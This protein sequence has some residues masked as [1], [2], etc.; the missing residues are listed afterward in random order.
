VAWAIGFCL[1]HEP[2]A[3]VIN[4]LLSLTVELFDL[5]AEMKRDVERIEIEPD[6]V[7]RPAIVSALGRE[8]FLKDLFDDECLV[9]HGVAG[10]IYQR[11][12]VVPCHLCQF[13]QRCLL[14][15]LTEF[16]SVA[17]AKFWPARWIVTEATP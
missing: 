12:P 5:A 15:R 2:D 17:F 14:S 10:T 7:L 4:V 3:L 13:N 16:L 11:Q 9:V 6:R 8:A 1:L